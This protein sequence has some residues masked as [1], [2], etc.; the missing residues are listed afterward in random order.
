MNAWHT[1]RQLNEKDENHFNW[2]HRLCG[3][4]CDARTI[5]YAASGESAIG[6]KAIGTNWMNEMA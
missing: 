1:K 2:S 4:R 5:A 3:R 6:R